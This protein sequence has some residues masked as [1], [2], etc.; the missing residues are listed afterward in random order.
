MTII[1]MNLSNGQQKILD[2]IAEKSGRIP[3]VDVFDAAVIQASGLPQEEVNKYLSQLEGLGLIKTLFGS[4]PAGASV[5]L[6]SIT[7]EGLEATSENQ[8]LR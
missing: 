4:K 8:P 7:K 5:K 2:I 6:I 3:N 1:I